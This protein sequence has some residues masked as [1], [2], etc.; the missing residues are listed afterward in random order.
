MDWERHKDYV[1]KIAVFDKNISVRIDSKP[2]EFPGMA[3]VEFYGDAQTEPNYA[4]IAQHYSLEYKGGGERISVLRNLED[5]IHGANE[6]MLAGTTSVD[7]AAE[8]KGKIS[9]IPHLALIGAINT[10]DH[11]LIVGL[12]GRRYGKELTPE[13]VKDMADNCYA[14]APGGGLTFRFNENPLDYTLEHEAMEELGIKKEE[15]RDHRPL[16][17]FKAK[18]I[19]PLG[20]KIVEFAETTLSSEEIIDRHREA[21][22]KYLDLCGQEI[23]EKEACKQV[24]EE[25]GCGDCWEH[26]SLLRVYSN[27][28]DIDFFI[29]TISSVDSI[30]EKNYIHHQ[31]CG[32]GVGALLL[33]ADHFA[34]LG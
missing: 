14:L 34:L 19:G 25:F 17:I 21:Y 10:E 4:A 8:K 5:V 18:K 27:T 12:R 30:D 1:D 15:I 33:V 6:L 9:S 26:S 23:P 7:V 13:R 28:S 29:S 3:P 2:F 31:K 24:A 16:G 22:R 20:Y 32:I 11:H